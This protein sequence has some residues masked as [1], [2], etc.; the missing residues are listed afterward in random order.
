MYDI[1]DMFI[2]FIRQH[3][4]NVLTSEELRNQYLASY[5]DHFDH[6]MQQQKKKALN[7]NIYLFIYLFIAENEWHLVKIINAFICCD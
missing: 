6:F 4:T 2:F 5:F 3:N 1:S 7:D